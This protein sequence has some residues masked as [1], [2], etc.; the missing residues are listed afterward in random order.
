[1]KEKV[2]KKTNRSENF[3]PDYDYLFEQSAMDKKPKNK[4]F[5]SSKCCL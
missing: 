2:Q 4:G 5:F 1:M 3:I